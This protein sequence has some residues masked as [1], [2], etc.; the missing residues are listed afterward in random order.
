MDPGPGIGRMVMRRDQDPQAAED[1]QA[2]LMKG[3]AKSG[4]TGEGSE[5]PL[6]GLRTQLKSPSLVR[7]GIL[8][9]LRHTL[10]FRPDFPDRLASP[11]VTMGY[12]FPRRSAPTA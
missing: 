8:S 12:G 9:S 2:E 6:T 7:S 4:R 11:T 3:T 5:L 10:A 1:A